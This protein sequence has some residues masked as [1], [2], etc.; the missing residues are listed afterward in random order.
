MSVQVGE[1]APRRLAVVMTVHNRCDTTERCLELLD[2]AAAEAGVE[3][4]RVV[5]DDGSTD[6]TPAMLTR[7]RRDGD[8]I[9]RGPGNLY[10]AGG[11]RRGFQ[12]ITEPFDHILM[13]N[14]DVDLRP[15][16]LS[17]LLERTEGCRDRLVAGQVVD[18][19]TGAPTYGGWRG[20]TRRRPFGYSLT[21][22]PE[23]QIE[24]MNGN[25]V[26]VGRDAYAVLGGLSETFKHGFADFDYG[27]RANQL[28]L[29]VLLSRRPVGECP[30]NPVEGTWRDESL[31]RRER[32]RLM[33][34]PTGM[35]PRE[36]LVFCWRHGGI[37]GL[38][39]AVWDWLRVLRSRAADEAAPARNRIG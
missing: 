7:V 37:F 32:I 20:R 35:P 12:E 19:Q 28:G 3:L 38:K 25:V 5:V 31:S 10:W 22:D 29:T 8:V 1:G 34:G 36:W 13:L 16:A 21:S 39:Y 33:R 30:R 9:V 15:D 27:L 6:G 26:L 23:G 18:P 2:A 11:M 17:T 14:D 24:A 4:R